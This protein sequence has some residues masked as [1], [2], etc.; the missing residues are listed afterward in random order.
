MNNNGFLQ[1]EV[2]KEGISD[3][4]GRAKVIF[5]LII[6]RFREMLYLK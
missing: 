5:L 3:I 4:S 6:I 2:K 1:D